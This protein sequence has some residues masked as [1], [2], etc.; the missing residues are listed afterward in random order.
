MKAP[1]AWFAIAVVVAL[2]FASAAAQQPA[3][4]ATP[5]PAPTASAASIPA[6]A[7]TQPTPQLLKVTEYRLPPDKMAKAQ[8]L[9]KI[10]VILYLFSLAFG[11][12]VLW[13]LLELGLAPRYRDVAERASKYSFV[14]MLIF[15]PLFMLT[16]AIISLPIEIYSQHVSRMYGISVQSWGSWAVDLCKAELIEMV[17]FVPLAWLLFWR[18]GNSPRSWWFQAWLIAACFVVSIVFVAPVILDPMFNKFEPL[19]KTQPQLVHEIEKV[20]HRGG[21][22]IP[23]D[24]M[25]EMKAS[26]K[27]T[28][29]N[30]YV[31]GFGAT[32]R[33]VMWDN[34]SRDMTVQETLFVFGH[35]QGHYVLKHIYKG[36]AFTVFLMFFGFWFARMLALAAL[37]RWGE[38]WGIR[39]ITDVAA[40]PVLLIVMTILNLASEPIANAFSRNL[41]HQ[42]DIY[43]LEVTHGLFP[44]NGAVAA[45]AFQKLG[46][47]G[48]SYPNPSAFLVF[49]SYDHPTT[50]SRVR[51][52]LAYDPWD[53]ADGPRYVK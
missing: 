37:A 19:E 51:F 44:D 43:G 45:S 38:H 14:Q 7:Q 22:T 35:E 4:T 3:R 8:A 6:P 18:I 12:V 15:L 10:R 13:V 49:W 17:I 50:A 31:T 53:S 21:I 20:N 1:A 28:T 40:V 26:E 33:V 25:F 5:S 41:E 46:E 42:A 30:A 16:T 23:R 27:V 11:V 47:K 2:S 9:Y 29:Y 39:G 36:I 52:S 32:K 48:Y 24:K 34:T